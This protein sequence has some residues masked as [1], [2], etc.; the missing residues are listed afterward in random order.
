MGYRYTT[1]K[2]E[3]ATLGTGN[4][5]FA[6]Q[7]AA[8]ASTAA[9]ICVVSRVE[10]SQS[11]TSTLQMIRGEFSTRNT[12]GTLTTTST[13]TVNIS[14]LGASTALAGATNVIGTAS[15][16]GTNSSADSGGTYT[17]IWPFSFANTAGYLFKPDPNEVIVIPPATV[18]VCR[19]L[20]SPTT[21]TG[22]NV[23]AIILENV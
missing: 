12:V 2:M 1:L 11:G 4:V 8:A 19:L 18:F 9:G 5:L 21:T 15:S 22:W 16:A 20:A 10:V 17:Q 6:I 13:A 14:P 23:A 3:N 7:T